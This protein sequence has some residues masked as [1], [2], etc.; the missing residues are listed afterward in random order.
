M[1]ALFQVLGSERLADSRLHA[2]ARQAVDALVSFPKRHVAWQI[3][4]FDEIGPAQRRLLGYTW[5]NAGGADG[6]VFAP[7][8]D[9]WPPGTDGAGRGNAEGDFEDEMLVMRPAAGA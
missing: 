8:G 6:D 9:F 7:G 3:K 5:W 4:D 2:G 1:L